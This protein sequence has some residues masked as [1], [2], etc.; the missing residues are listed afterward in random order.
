MKRTLIFF[1]FLLIF[2]SGVPFYAHAITI[3]PARIEISGDPGQTVRGEILLFDDDQGNKTQFITFENFEPRGDSGAPY[4]I[5]AKDGL[6]TWIIAPTEVYVPVA[7]QITIPFSISIPVTA[8]PGGYF[9]AIFFGNQPPN[10]KEGGEVTVGGKIGVLILLRVNGEIEEGG[11]LISFSLKDQKRIITKPLIIFEYSLNNIG[12]DR[13]IPRGQIKLFNTFRFKTEEIN[14]NRNEGSVLPNS[15]RRFEV[16]LNEK[17]NVN[18]PVDP[19]EKDGFF[20]TVKTQFKDFRFGWYTAKLEIIWGANQSATEKY[21]FFVFPWHAL[22]VVFAGLFIVWKLFKIVIKKYNTW[23]LAKMGV[24]QQNVPSQ[25]NIHHQNPSAQKQSTV[26]RI[27]KI[28][29]TKDSIQP[30]K[31]AKRRI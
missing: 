31:K 28:Q 18:E 7:E 29:S 1:T 8:K 15:T 13:V 9:G 21:G 30:L 24:Y 3:S 25:K 12:G 10:S 6:A 26:S 17:L 22:L 2:F 5:G 23:L 16:Y 4:F 11:G 14:A 19:E 27:P 20:T